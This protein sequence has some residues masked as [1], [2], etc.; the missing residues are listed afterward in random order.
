MEAI[1][2]DWSGETMPASVNWTN[3]EPSIYFGKL[4]FPQFT[5]AFISFERN[6]RKWPFEVLYSG[7]ASMLA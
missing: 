5:R 3:R 2:Y 1:K 7:Y 6:G 4:D